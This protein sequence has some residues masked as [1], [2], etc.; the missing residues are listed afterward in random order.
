MTSAAQLTLIIDELLSAKCA[1]QA[2][3]FALLEG[4]GLLPAKLQKKTVKPAKPVSRFASQAAQD[5]CDEADLELAD[6]FTGSSSGGKITVKDIKDLIKKAEVKVNASPAAKAFASANGIDIG[7]VNGSGPDGKVLVSDLKTPE[8]KK[9]KKE[10]KV[11]EVKKSLKITPAAKKLAEKWQIDEDDLKEITGTGANGAIK[12]SDMKELVEAAK[13]AWEE[14][15][16][17]ASSED[18]EQ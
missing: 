13:E 16:S 5:A 10:K 14:E 17:P 15:E 1:D 12:G 8:P 4:K 2:Q 9:E 11:K 3:A 7:S 18:E 6:D